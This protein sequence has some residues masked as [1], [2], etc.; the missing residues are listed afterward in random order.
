MIKFC[1]KNCTISANQCGFRSN[2]SCIDAIVSITAFIRREIDRKS[3]GQACF[4]DLQKAFDTLD[5]KILLQKMEKYGFRGPIHDMMKKYLSDRWQY[6]DKN[7]K[8][9]NQKWI[10][11]GVPQGSILGVF[12]FLFY[13]SNLDSSGGNSKMSMFTDDTTI[14]NAKKNVSFT[15]QREM[16]LISDWMTCKEITISIDNCEVMCFG[17]GN[18][19]PLKIKDTPIQCKTTSKYLG[20]HVDK[21]LRFNQHIEYLVKKLNKFCGIFYRIR[22][23]FPRNCLLMFYNSYAK[24]LIN[25]GIIAYGA[26]AKTNLSEIE[27]AQRGIM[28]AFF[29]KIKMDSITNV[30][31]EKGSLT[32]YELYLA[33]LL[34]ELFRQLWSEAPNTYLPKTL[35]SKSTNTRGKTKGLLPSI[36]SRTLTKKKSLAIGLRKAYNWLT[37]SK[38]LPTNLKKKHD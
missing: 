5:H 7:G 27:M 13:I 17:S 31:R 34:K 20:L 23:M 37:I 10:T 28:S 14:F 29:F 6:V 24:T 33:E 32:V 30:L 26:T 9:T 2:R 4:I 16:D 38:L 22:H 18:P 1:E 3:L 19:P 8:E 21:W 36:Y 11:T 35:E 25:Y 12:L 15:M